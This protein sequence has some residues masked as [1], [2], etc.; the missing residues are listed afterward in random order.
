[1]YKQCRTAQSAARQRQ[2]LEGFLDAMLQENFESISVSSLCD[3]L[4]IPRKSFYR[5]FSSKEGALNALIDQTLLDFESFTEKNIRASGS[6][7]QELER[8]FAYWLHKRRLLDALQKSGLSGVLVNRAIGHSLLERFDRGRFRTMEEQEAGEY[9]TLFAVSGFLSVVIQW[10]HGGYRQTAQQM[11]Q[12]G[13]RLVS[14][15]LAPNLLGSWI[16]LCGFA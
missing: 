2:L 6:A 10:H 12:I 1:M 11:A 8:M 9:I 14:E 3:R 4:E 15:P 7:Q 5:Y 13:L 16:R